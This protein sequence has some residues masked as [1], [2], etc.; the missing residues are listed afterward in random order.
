MDNMKEWIVDY[1][2]IDRDGVKHVDDLDAFPYGTNR[3]PVDAMDIQGALEEARKMLLAMS[4]NRDW[5]EVRVWNIGI[6][7][8]EIW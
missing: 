2:F 8:D 3:I 5:Q 4:C 6:V 1:A 7:D